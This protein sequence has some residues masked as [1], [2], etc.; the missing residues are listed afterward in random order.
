MRRHI[1]GSEVEKVLGALAWWEGE[2][3]ARA[4]GA[5]PRTGIGLIGYGEGGPLALYAG[6]TAGER[7]DVVC[8]SGYFGPREGLWQEPI[9]RNVFGLLKD[10]GDAEL[11][12]MA[13]PAAVVVEASKAPE[14]SG[15]PAP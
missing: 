12:A 4:G 14:V 7:V 8:V 13:S 6:A 11:A 3:S 10:H 9:Y 15:P 1:S 2:D 5:R